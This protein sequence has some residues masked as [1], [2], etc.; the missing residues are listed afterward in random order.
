LVFRTEVLKRSFPSK[1]FHVYD[2]RCLRQHSYTASN[3]L[4][5]FTKA[6]GFTA[7]EKSWNDPGV[8][9]PPEPQP[10]P[11]LLIEAERVGVQEGRLALD[12]RVADHDAR[13]KEEKAQ[14]DREKAAAELQLEDKGLEVE[15]EKT[16]ISATV[17]RETKQA[18][19]DDKKEA[20]KDQKPQVAVQV[21]AEDA[22]QKIAETFADISAQQI[23]SAEAL[24]EASKQIAKAMSAKKRIV[25][26]DKGKARRCRDGSVSGL[27]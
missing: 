1:S 18:D 24:V 5:G 25:R 9:P 16:A 21:N 2:W 17:Q 4:V 26:D 8:N 22:L 15:R 6:A 19:I 23:K 12:E 13:M 10:D 7:G 14:L 3:A 11:K 20:R 27:L